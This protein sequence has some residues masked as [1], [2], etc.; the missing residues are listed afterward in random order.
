MASTS[1]V[2]VAVKRS[3]YLVF[4]ATETVLNRAR[5]SV[6][7]SV[8]TPSTRAIRIRSAGNGPSRQSSGSPLANPFTKG[9]DAD[10]G[11][12]AKAIARQTTGTTFMMDPPH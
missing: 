8:S 3:V 12:A 4:G 2:N 7:N 5:V 6:T 11:T 10:A 1:P 9:D